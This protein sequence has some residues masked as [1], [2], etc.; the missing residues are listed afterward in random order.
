MRFPPPAKAGGFQRIILMNPKIDSTDFG[1]ITIAG[2]QYQHDVIIR[3]DGN[4]A[5]RK[6]KLSKSIYG[7]SHIISLDEA[8]YIY[9]ES[10][11]K[12]I[13]GTGQFDRVRLS[14]NAANFFKEKHIPVMMMPTQIAIQEWNKTKGAKIGL[15]H[16]TC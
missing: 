16:V 1:S 10:A 7:T 4:I 14:E 15:F 6:K 12:L 8:K 11:E 3:L 5:K 2:T 9:E 13:I